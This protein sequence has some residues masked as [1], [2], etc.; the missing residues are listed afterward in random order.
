MNRRPT[1]VK[2]HEQITKKRSPTL[3]TKAK[4]FPNYTIEEEAAAQG[5]DDQQETRSEGELLTTHQNATTP[6]F[7]S[8][9]G[10]HNSPSQ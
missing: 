6:A 4:R 3:R 7:R 2:H 9:N 5:G 1:N 10:Q 8:A